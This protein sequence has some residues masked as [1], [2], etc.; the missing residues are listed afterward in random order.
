MV[1]KLVYSILDEAFFFLHV[2]FLKINPN[3]VLPVEAAI[4]HC[5]ETFISAL[6]LTPKSFS[7]Y[8]ST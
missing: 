1:S 7:F 6:I 5:F 8:G 4:P 3:I 2:I